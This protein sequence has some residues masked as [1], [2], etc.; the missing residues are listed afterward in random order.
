MINSSGLV[1]DGL[2]GDCR[3]NHQTTWTYNQGVILAGLAQL[4]LA[5]GDV[6]LLAE[7]ERIARAAIRHLTAGGVLQESCTGP[8]APA[9]PT[10]TGHRSRGYSCG[11]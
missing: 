1:N 8:A 9:T 11:T 4:Y 5:T 2:A 3:N 6:S 7:G 10:R